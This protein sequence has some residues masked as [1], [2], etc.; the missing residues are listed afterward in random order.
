MLVWTLITEVKLSA[1]AYRLFHE[2]FSSIVRA[3]V[4]G[5]YMCLFSQYFDFH[6]CMTSISNSC[7]S[8]SQ[9]EQ[10]AFCHLEFI[11]GHKGN[12]GV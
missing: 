9:H 3:K 5:N 6:T 7:L 4:S 12:S 2:D 1:F 8:G 10:K 11:R